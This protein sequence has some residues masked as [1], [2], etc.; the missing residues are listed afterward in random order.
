MFC[1]LIEPELHFIIKFFYPH[2]L[3]QFYE[4]EHE[5]IMIMK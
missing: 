3:R 1:C 4:N 2:W 5:N